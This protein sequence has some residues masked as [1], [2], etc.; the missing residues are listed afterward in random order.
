MQ[1][2]GELLLGDETG[3]LVDLA[4]EAENDDRADSAEVSVTFNASTQELTITGAITTTE[5]EEFELVAVVSSLTATLLL[6]E[7]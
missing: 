3:K 5:G 2:A 4:T 6:P 1:A 7:A